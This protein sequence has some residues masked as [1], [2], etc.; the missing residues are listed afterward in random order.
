VRAPSGD[1]VQPWRFSLS[2]TTLH[3]YNEPARDRSLYNVGQV[4]SLI[5]HG[6]L[7]ENLAVCAPGLGL[8]I[9]EMDMPSAVGGSQPV[10]SV[11]FAACDASPH[12]LE[13]AVQ[14]RCT[15]RRPYKRTPIDSELIARVTDG[16]ASADVGVHAA[17]TEDTVSAVARTASINERIVLENQTLHRFLFANVRWSASHA[18]TT[19]DGFHINTFEL[20]P[21]ER[22]VFSLIRHWPA[23]RVAHAVGIPR[24]V[25]RAN[26]QRYA[27]SGM[28]LAFSRLSDSPRTWVH[29]G[30]SFQ[31]AWLQ[32]T[33]AGLAAQ[34]LAGVPLLMER[35]RRGE[36]DAL[37]PVHRSWIEQA[38][39]E[40]THLFDAGS[41]PLAIAL[42]IGFSVEPTARTERLAP[43]IAEHPSA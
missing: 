27:A 41:A 25:S 30:R 43:R 19:Q 26:A 14:E 42:R 4:A 24:V 1:N 9:T 16:V 29:V 12:P 31:R 20:Q 5:A 15:N 2:G 39:A 13:R 11:S 22:A 21:P 17:E 37:S 8:A 7:L 40:L 23:M 33:A 6:A 3:I 35:I 36:G 18:Q 28:I 10:A 38:N 34:P 32:A